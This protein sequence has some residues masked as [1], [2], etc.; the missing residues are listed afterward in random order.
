MGKLLRLI[1]IAAILTLL[2]GCGN[3]DEPMP[4]PQPVQETWLMTYDDYHA[5]LDIK[6]DEKQKYKDLSREVT[7]LRD[8]DEIAIKGIFAEYPDAWVKGRI[9]SNKVFIGNNQAIGTDGG[10]TVYFHWA[11]VNHYSEHQYTGNTSF[12]LPESI[13]FNISA[14]NSF[15]ISD[16][17]NTMTEHNSESEIAFMYDKNNESDIHYHYCEDTG[18]PDTDINVNISFRKVSD[19]GFDNN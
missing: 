5:L 18:F 6:E 19:A 16:D 3:G 9:K 17:G 15:I 12:I 8:G 7:I 14:G 4:D 1:C 10:E 13:E 11:W 2:A